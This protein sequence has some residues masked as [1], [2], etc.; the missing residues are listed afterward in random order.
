MF[1]V[2]RMLRKMSSPEKETCVV[3]I[4]PPLN[5]FMDPLTKVWPMQLSRDRLLLI[6]GLVHVGNISV[7]EKQYH[8]QEGNKIT[9]TGFVHL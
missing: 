4:D 7:E 6:P 1:Y 8:V 9:W 3:M 5:G 2:T